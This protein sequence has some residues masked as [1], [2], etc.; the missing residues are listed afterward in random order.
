MQLMLVVAN[1]TASSSPNQ[2]IK[3]TVSGDSADDKNTDNNRE[4]SLH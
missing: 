4:R 2:L 1:A 3:P